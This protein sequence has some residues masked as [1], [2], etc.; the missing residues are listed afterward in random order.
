MRKDKDL[1]VLCQTGVR[2]TQ[3]VNI[4]RSSGFERV[5]AV[6]GGVQAWKVSGL[7]LDRQKGP[8]PIMR[9]VQIVAGSLALIGGL[10]PNL[11]WIAIIVGAGLVFAGVSGTCGMALVLSKLPWNKPQPGQSKGKDTCGS[12][13]S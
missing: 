7:P 10:I 8:I 3:A 11:R 6:E 2:T 13:V 1:Y 4:L 9:Q 12:C 5:Q